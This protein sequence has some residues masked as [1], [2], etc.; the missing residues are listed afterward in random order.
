MREQ[1]FLSHSEEGL[2]K[3]EMPVDEAA[4]ATAGP[5]VQ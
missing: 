5:V 3:K 1:N 2:N 4:A